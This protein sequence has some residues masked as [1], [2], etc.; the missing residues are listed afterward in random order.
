MGRLALKV[1]LSFAQLECEVTAERIR[2]KFA[3]SK[4]K[5]M[6]M[7]GRAPLGYGV[8][9]RKLVIVEEEATIRTVFDVYLGTRSTIAA[10]RELTAMGITS[11]VQKPV[12]GQPRGGIPATPIE[13]RGTGALRAARER[14]DGTT[15]HAPPHIGRSHTPALSDKQLVESPLERIEVFDGR[16][17]P[18]L[19]EQAPY[20]QGRL[21]DTERRIT[22]GC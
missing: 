21:P 7:G 3:A 14:L 22:S 19:T 10:A 6:F 2:D 11:K 5:G 17:A 13:A 1:L 8:E 16:I 9:N 12:K 18:P 4:R 20:K 15:L